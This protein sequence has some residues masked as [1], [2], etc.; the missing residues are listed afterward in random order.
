M[1]KGCLAA[2]KTMSTHVGASSKLSKMFWRL[3]LLFNLCAACLWLRGSISSIYLGICAVR[4]VRLLWNVNS[5]KILNIFI[6]T[7]WVSRQLLP[8]RDVLMDAHHAGISYGF[9][10]FAKD[11][12]VYKHTHGGLMVGYLEGGRMNMYLERVCVCY[13]KCISAGGKRRCAGASIGVVSFTLATPQIFARFAN[14]RKNSLIIVP[15]TH[16]HIHTHTHR[17]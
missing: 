5:A 8:P 1:R 17:E 10:Y 11:S 6:G 7:W 16:T 14:F 12:C 4:Y 3:N 15:Y 9:S 13:E 2:R